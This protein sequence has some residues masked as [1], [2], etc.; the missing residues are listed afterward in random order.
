ML[1]DWNT[2]L[3]KVK[4]VTV[5][6]SNISMEMIWLNLEE[7]LNTLASDVIQLILE[8]KPFLWASDSIH[9]RW[10]LELDTVVTVQLG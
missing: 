9:S 3:D 1:H 5:L 8:L 6:T 2:V 10:V 4:Q 7:V